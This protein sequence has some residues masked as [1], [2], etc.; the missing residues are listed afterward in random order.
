MKLHRSLLLA[1]AASATTATA[2]LPDA[3]KLPEVPKPPQPP[4]ARSMPRENN[5]EPEQKPVAYMGVLTR[6]VPVELR[7]QFGLPEGFGL[8]V[9]EVMP[10]SPAKTAGIKTHDVLV[11]F[12]DQQLVNMEQLLTLVRSK[13]KGDNVSL[14]IITGGKETQ[15]SVTLAERMMPANET[16]HT[17]RG[18]PG[19]PPQMQHFFGGGGQ[20][21]R[22]QMEQVQKQM[23]EYQERMQEWHRGDHRSPFPQMSPSRREDD[24]R[25][26]NRPGG[27]G[28][29]DGEK[30]SEIRVESHAAANIL[31]RDDSG[32]YQLKS[33]DGKRTFIARPKEG[34]E[35]S[36]PVNT[37][38]E[39]QAVPEKF[40]EKLRLFD[41]VRQDF[42][43]ERREGGTPRSPEG[44]PRETPPPAPKGRE[45]S[46]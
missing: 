16:R 38:A 6:E 40:R 30:R 8:M 25:D 11:K 1:L 44:G 22:E 39:R 34:E 23:R 26:G 21:V 46:V 33:E 20:D 15:I 7:S 36:W 42:Q 27:P 37:D 43:F 2:Q 32:E 31:R 35:Q 41:N 13:K 9:D 45:T 28:P 18:F 17:P 24:H 14:T 3:P 4:E 5:G 12:A 10:D 29:R 19:M